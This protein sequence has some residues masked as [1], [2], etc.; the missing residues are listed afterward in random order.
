[1]LSLPKIP[2]R[3]S[4]RPKRFAQAGMSLIEL[5]I[6]M[7]VLT[8]G[9]LGALVMVMMGMHADTRNKNDTSAVVLDQEILEKFATLKNYPKTGTVIITDCA[10]IGAN[11]HLASL[12]EA[13][14][15]GAGATVYTAANAP[16]PGQVGDINWTVAGPGL[17]TAAV[18]GYSMQYTTCNSDIFEIRW[19]ILDLSNTNNRL[20]MLTVSSRQISAGGSTNSMLYSNPTTLR[21]IIQK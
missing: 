1:M 20:S 15:P 18:A 7:C 6:A 2:S 16:T 12:T 3:P 19:N 9:M 4:R 17:A 5:L 8:V 21:T 11:S 10:L 14:T 13:L